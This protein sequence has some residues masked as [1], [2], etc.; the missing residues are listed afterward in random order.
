MFTYF[1]LFLHLFTSRHPYTLTSDM[2][3]ARNGERDRK[4][5]KERVR[6]CGAKNTNKQKQQQSARNYKH[7]N[8]QIYLYSLQSLNE[9]ITGALLP[10]LAGALLFPLIPLGKRDTC[11]NRNFH[12]RLLR[13]LLLLHHPVGPSRTL[14]LISIAHG[15]QLLLLIHAY[16]HW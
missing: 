10:F 9:L 16:F 12:G 6:E 4:R 5:T 11:K 7:K 2:H 15:C 13:A 1:I 8:K 14:H 3:D